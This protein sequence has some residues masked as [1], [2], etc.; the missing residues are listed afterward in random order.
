MAQKPVLRGEVGCVCVACE[1]S[2]E[3]GGMGRPPPSPVHLLCVYTRAHI[4]PAQA[5]PIAL[6]NISCRTLPQRPSQLQ[7]DTSQPSEC[8]VVYPCVSGVWSLPGSAA[9]SDLSDSTGS[10]L[11]IDKHRHLLAGKGGTL[12]DC[13]YLLAEKGGISAQESP[14]PCW[15]NAAACDLTTRYF[16]GFLPVDPSRVVGTVASLALSTG[17]S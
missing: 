13:H 15:R 14:S 8:A 16:S 17:P 5:A 4:P 10:L 1:V 11:S 2:V 3:R 7:K 12:T 9:P 6:A